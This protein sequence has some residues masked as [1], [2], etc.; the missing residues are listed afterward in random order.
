MTIRITSVRRSGLLLY[1]VTEHNGS[2]NATESTVKVI[3]CKIEYNDDADDYNKLILN[4]LAPEFFLNFSTPCI[5]NVNITGTER[6]SI[7][8]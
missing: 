3:W 8:K 1:A 4:H 6:G 7:M 5:S 2:S